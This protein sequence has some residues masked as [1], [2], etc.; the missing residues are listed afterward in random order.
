MPIIFAQAIM[1]IP[2]ALAGLSKIHHNQLL[3]L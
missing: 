2:A 1:F 3:V